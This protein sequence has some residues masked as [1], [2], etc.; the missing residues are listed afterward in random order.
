MEPTWD[1]PFARPARDSNP[2]QRLHRAASSWQPCTSLIIRIAQLANWLS[3]VAAACATTTIVLHTAPS[4]FIPHAVAVRVPGDGVRP[5]REGLISV[6]LSVGVRT[7]L[8]WVCREAVGTEVHL[9][10]VVHAVHIRVRAVPPRPTRCSSC[11]RRPPPAKV[12]M[13]VVRPLSTYVVWTMSLLA[14]VVP[15]RYRFILLRAREGE[16]PDNE[17]RPDQYA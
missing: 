17:L 2:G 1:N 16:T 9:L 6:G 12:T 10:G 14:E 15:L 11:S 7:G 8:P 5:L 3:T 13:E 4:A